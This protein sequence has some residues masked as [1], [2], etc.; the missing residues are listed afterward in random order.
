MD[1]N[2]LMPSATDVAPWGTGGD[3]A[4]GIIPID[5]AM[6]EFFPPAEEYLRVGGNLFMPQPPSN[7]P[8]A[9]PG[10]MGEI[11]LPPVNYASGPVSPQIWKTVFHDPQTAVPWTEDHNAQ[12]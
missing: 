5:R 11:G 1:D 12:G 8:Y 10:K 2:N 4:P 7:M 9:T 3:H 6:S